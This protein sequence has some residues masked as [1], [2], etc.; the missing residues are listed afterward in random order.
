[1][2]HALVLKARSL[3]LQP[4]FKPESYPHGT[5]L[6]D[7]G[8]LHSALK[9]VSHHQEDYQHTLKSDAYPFA[10]EKHLSCP[11]LP[12]LASQP[13]HR[14]KIKA[15]DDYPFQR[16]IAKGYPL[17]PSM[18]ALYL[19][20]FYKLTH[21]ILNALKLKGHPDKTYIGW[22]NKGFD[23]LV[24]YFGALPKIAKPFLEKHRAQLAQRYGLPIL[25]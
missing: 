23:F 3:R 8:D 22:I 19:K 24:V 13:C 12:H 17:P 1:M 18:A 4:L 25:L 11:R 5:H 7:S 6:K 20:P 15:G 21:T 16:R 10:L 2:I 9:K 14:L